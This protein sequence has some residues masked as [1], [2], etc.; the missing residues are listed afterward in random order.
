MKRSV[1]AGSFA[2]EAY[3][4]VLFQE[5]CAAGRFHMVGLAVVFKS[6]NQ[7]MGGI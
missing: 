7:S 5:P 2:F 4:F 1:P 6:G 3:W